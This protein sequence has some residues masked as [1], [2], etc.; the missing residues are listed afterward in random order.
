MQGFMPPDAFMFDTS[1]Q[2]VMQTAMGG[3]GTLFG[4]LVGA[5]VWLYLRGT[6]TP[7]V[8][9]R[10]VHR[11]SPPIVAKPARLEG[12]LMRQLE[13]IATVALMASGQSVFAESGSAL[14]PSAKTAA[15]KA[16]ADDGALSRQLPKSLLRMPPPLAQ[17]ASATPTAGTRP[18]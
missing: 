12:E 2:L 9:T 8:A 18:A 4:P 11:G 5:T 10:A 15:A 13:L 6:P 3:A 14:A 16:K 1:G 17:N 7:L